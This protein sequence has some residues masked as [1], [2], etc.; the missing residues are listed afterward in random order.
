MRKGCGKKF[1]WAKCEPRICGDDLILPSGKR[2]RSFYLCD[3]CR[4]DVNHAEGG[5]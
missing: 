4:D 5:K 2:K 1:N 3:D